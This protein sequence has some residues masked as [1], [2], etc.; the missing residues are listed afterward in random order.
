[1]REI[2]SCL[3]GVEGRNYYVVVLVTEWLQYLPEIKFYD[4]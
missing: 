1:V 4:D 2:S 3:S